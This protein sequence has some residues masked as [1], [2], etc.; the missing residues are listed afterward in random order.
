MTK[1]STGTRRASTARVAAKAAK[2]A[3]QRERVPS[4]A[5]TRQKVGKRTGDG[6]IASKT[7]SK[8]GHVWGAYEDY[9]DCP[10]R[11][12]GWPA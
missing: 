7:C 2:R 3:L 6:G 5:G 10:Y 12:D 1:A 9:C 11:P 8:C 4:N